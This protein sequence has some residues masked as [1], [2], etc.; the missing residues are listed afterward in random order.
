M[1]KAWQA[2]AECSHIPN[3]DTRA[4]AHARAHART[5]THIPFRIA[6][7]SSP[8]IGMKRNV[9]LLPL[10]YVFLFIFYSH[11]WF[12]WVPDWAMAH[13]LYC[14]SY[15]TMCIQAKVCQPSGYLVALCAR[16]VREVDKCVDKFHLPQFHG[17]TLSKALNDWNNKYNSPSLLA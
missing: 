12:Y 10:P 17:C 11:V 2:R 7:L 8:L 9:K 1:Y 3:T 13:L 5:H 15:R 16:A 14:S 4:N 6:W